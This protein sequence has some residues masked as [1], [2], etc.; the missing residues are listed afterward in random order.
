MGALLPGASIPPKV[1]EAK[2]PP[3]SLRRLGGDDLGE[4]RKLTSQT[5]F[6]QTNLKVQ[7]KFSLY[8]ADLCNFKNQ[9]NNIFQHRLIKILAAKFCN[10]YIFHI[11]L[12]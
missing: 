9:D 2:S 7:S 1:M 12:L 6:V 8:F 10:T 5:F 11:L 4:R 3:K